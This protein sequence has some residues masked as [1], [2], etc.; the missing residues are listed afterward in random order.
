[1]RRCWSTERF[2]VLDTETTGLDPAADRAI[3][4]GAI[5]IVGG[6]I[7]LGDTF[8]RL[9]ATGVP[10]T[11]NSLIVHGLTDAT[12]ARGTA[13]TEALSDF[14]VWIDD[15][16]LVAHHAAFD[17]AMLNHTSIELHGIPL[18]NLV[19]DTTHLAAR[20]ERGQQLG[21]GLD[22]LL[23]RYAIAGSA[24]RH[25]ALGDA[26]LTARLLLKLLKRLRAR[27]L[28]SLRDLALSQEP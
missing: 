15:A 16:I 17:L 24:E 12:V 18:Q 22:T 8:H 19:L 7:H 3:S 21:Y 25:T 11:R 23:E 14:L 20:L 6:R 5:S 28:G 2:V 4:L 10:S 1:M 13:P 26:I 27:G 9:L